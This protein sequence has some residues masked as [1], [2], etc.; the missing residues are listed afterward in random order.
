MEVDCVLSSGAPL[1]KVTLSPTSTVESLQSK[2]IGTLREKRPYSWVVDGLR[3]VTAFRSTPWETAH[4]T[5]ALLRTFRPI[6]C[7]YKGLI[8]SSATVLSEIGTTVCVLRPSD[9][10]V[11]SIDLQGNITPSV[12]NTCEEIEWTCPVPTSQSSVIQLII[13]TS[14]GCHAVCLATLED[15]VRALKCRLALSLKTSAYSLRLWHHDQLLSDDQSL[16]KLGLRHGHRLLA[17]QT[18]QLAYG[19][20]ASLERTVFPVTEKMSALKYVQI[21]EAEWQPSEVVAYEQLFLSLSTYKHYL[22]ASK[23][24]RLVTLSLSSQTSTLALIPLRSSLHTAKLCISSQH[25]F[26]AD[27]ISL[28]FVTALDVGKTAKDYGLKERD[29]LILSKR[30]VRQWNIKLALRGTRR[31]IMHLRANSSHLVSE[32]KTILRGRKPWLGS[33]FTIL[34]GGD[35]FDD[36]E[37]LGDYGLPQEC[38]VRITSLEP[39]CP[40]TQ[41]DLGLLRFIPPEA[42]RQLH[43]ASQSSLELFDSGQDPNSLPK[44]LRTERYRGWLQEPSVFVRVVAPGQLLCVKVHTKA[45]A[46]VIKAH[47]QVMTREKLFRLICNEKELEAEKTLEEQGIG[48]EATVLLIPPGA[49]LVSVQTAGGSQAFP[50]VLQPNRPLQ[51]LH[52]SIPALSGTPPHYQSFTYTKRLS[53]GQLPVA[54]TRYE[55]WLA[56]GRGAEASVQTDRGIVMRVECNSQ[57][58]KADLRSRLEGKGLAFL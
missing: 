53:E 25:N 3:I 47:L 39:T 28:T 50:V 27:L 8:L 32:I 23:S 33:S 7:G 37:T 55:L 4:E 41:L 16:E 31:K 22:V 30:D 35:I 10:F 21:L 56:V 26:P 44:A 2:V 57:D 12:F 40:L 9:L 15:T 49:I 29:T 11:N 6:I 14:T 36:N 45:T 52:T 43:S 58:T 42:P 51:A 19:C 20:N 46:A 5:V 24:S 13:L 34:R 17:V 54:V 48:Q 38:P 1:F 18:E